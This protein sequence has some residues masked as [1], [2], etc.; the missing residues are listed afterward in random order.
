[1]KI[2]FIGLGIMG[3]RMAARLRGAG[4]EL[5]IHNRTRNQ[6]AENL[7]GEGATWAESPEALAGQADIVV[8]MLA[9]PGAVRAMALDAQGLLAG[10]KPGLLWVDASTVDPAFSREMAA[11]ARDGGV[12][13]VDAPVAGSRAPAESGELI[14]MAGGS[15]AAIDRAM[16]LLDVMGKKTLRLGENG[17]GASLKMVVNLLLGQ[18]MVAFSEAFALGRS[19]GL[20]GNR[21][22]DVLTATPVTAPI[23]AAVRPKLDAENTEANFPLKHMLKD[24]KLAEETAREQGVPLDSG[25][26]ASNIFAATLEAGRGEQDFSSVFFHLNQA[27]A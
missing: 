18:S 19:M 8:T 17:M 20:D 5:L 22:F 13:F 14:F 27:N 7:L 12:D 25:S 24:L 16:P 6:V 26:A 10:A 2:G 15:E 3:G 23:I 9:D 1:M 4:F 11:A 21:L